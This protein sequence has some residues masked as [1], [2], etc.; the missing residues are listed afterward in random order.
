MA[1]K[2]SY[3]ASMAAPM[4][5]QAYYSSYGYDQSYGTQ[6]YNQTYEGYNYDYNMAQPQDGPQEEIELVI[7]PPKKVQKNKVAYPPLVVA[8]SNL[9]PAV[10]YY[11]Q[12]QA[13]DQNGGTINVFNAGQSYMTYFQSAS[14]EDDTPEGLDDSKKYAVFYDTK[15]AVANDQPYNLIATLIEQTLTEA[16]E[17]A[18]Y[19]I[20]MT[21]TL[22]KQPEKE[23]TEWE[24]QI[25]DAIYKD[26]N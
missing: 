5:Q 8:F 22:K 7:A 9:K 17:V 15:L 21:C 18:H 23:L 1:Y 20:Q 13:K 14:F 3:S 2:A 10:H 6:D 11:I 25:L 24:N 19:Q 16:R 4:N 12:L 26:K